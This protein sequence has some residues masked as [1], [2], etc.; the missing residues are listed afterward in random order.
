MKNFTTLVSMLLLTLTLFCVN[1]SAQTTYG[2]YDVP[3]IATFKDGG[4]IFKLERDVVIHKKV[5]FIA[6]QNK[7]ININ[8]GNSGTVSLAA[9]ASFTHTYPNSS[10]GDQNITISYTILSQNSTVTV[11]RLVKLT[12]RG[13][14]AVYQKPDTTWKVTTTEDFSPLCIN[15]AYPNANERPQKGFATVYVKYGAGHNNKLVRPFIFVDGIDF[16]PTT[17]KDSDNNN[18]IVR[19]GNTGW[20]VL[21]MGADDGRLDEPINGVLDHDAFEQYPAAFQKLVAVSQENGGDSYD[22]MFVDFPLA[23][24]LLTAKQSRMLVRF[25]KTD[26]YY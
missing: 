22:I 6:P 7:A 23:R 15:S 17:Y 13:T 24:H 9:G 4:W 11:N 18:E 25:F 14:Q 16:D 2:M 26:T 21:T 3:I 8:T 20:D 19:H 1:A 10:S 5:R 12:I